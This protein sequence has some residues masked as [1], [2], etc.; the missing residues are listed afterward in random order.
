MKGRVLSCGVK[1]YIEHSV[2]HCCIHQSTASRQHN[3][4]QTIMGSI[5]SRK[6]PAV[7]ASLN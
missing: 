4:Q 5:E 2:F 1:S 7:L 3:K 6:F